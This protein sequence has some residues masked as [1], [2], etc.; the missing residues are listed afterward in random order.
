MSLSRPRLKLRDLLLAVNLAVLWLPLLGLEAL[1]LYDSATAVRQRPDP[2]DRIGADR[3]GR[4]RRCQLPRGADAAS[5]PDLGRSGLRRAARWGWA[6]ARTLRRRRPLASAPGPT[7]SGRRFDTPTAARSDLVF[8]AVRSACPRCRRGTANVAARRPDHDFGGNRH[9]GCAGYGG[10][11]HRLQPGPIPDA[12][13]GSATRLG[14][15]RKC[16]AP[17]TASR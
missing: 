6:L 9:N 12:V 17:W 11:D 10:R 16:D 2:P 5:A 15:S 7:G 8:R 3:P 13:R 4:F 1:R 14:R